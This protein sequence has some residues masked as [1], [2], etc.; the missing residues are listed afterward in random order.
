MIRE[1]FH[2][3]SL[4]GFEE[5][6]PV[7]VSIQQFY[8]I[9]INDFAVTVATTALWISE[10]QMLRETEKIIRRDIEFLPLKSYTNIREGNALR[11]DW[12]SVVPKERL[13]YIIGN[14]PFVGKK[15]QTKEQKED[16]TNLFDKKAKGIGNIDYVAGWYKKALNTIYKT[17]TKVAFVSTNSITQGEQVPI[18]WRELY[19]Q[20][21]NII[22]ARRTFRWD[23][24]ASEK[25]HVH[26][27]IIGFVSGSYKNEK[28][29]Y[30]GE[31]VK[32]VNEINPYLVAGSPLFIDKREKPICNVPEILYGSMPIDDGHLIL[33]REDV[34]TLLRESADNAKFIRKYAGGAEIINN[35]ERWC[36]WLQGFSPDDLRK[37]PIVCHRVQQTREF[38]ESSR[39]PQTLKL[40]QTPWLF[41][42]IRQPDTNML[43]VPKV[44]SERRRYIPIAF[45]S[46]ETIVNGSA[47]IVPNA[48]LYDF[49][50]IISNVHMAWMRAVCGRMKS[51]Y[52]YSGS[53]VYNNFPWP[54]PTDEQ[55]KRIEQSAAAILQS[56]ALY[57]TSTLAGLYDDNFMPPELR[58]AH[59]ANDR[60]VMQAYGFPVNSVFTE[61]QIVAE[62]F[63]LYEEMTK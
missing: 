1:R 36:L 8:G 32:R 10:A 21:I 52:Q 26:C 19:K 4:I 11:I 55:R 27:V 24:E 53:N 15:E 62:L 34:D 17:N 18:L 29:I 40:A 23:S 58:R 50:I 20:D 28:Y 16:L 56:R 25:A 13:N 3:Q 57:P 6:N 49:G 45:L 37:S 41:G 30:D 31:A 14:P 35:R 63:R 22:F 46:S 39:R 7:K 9:E 48:T 51:D 2:D 5:M 47:L 43:V 59:Q 54:T 33:E 61:S 12:Q 42:E 60:A 38:R 44:S